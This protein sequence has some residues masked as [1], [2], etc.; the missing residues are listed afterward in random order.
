MGILWMQNRLYRIYR[1]VS[2]RSGLHHSH[3]VHLCFSL[4]LSS[5]FPCCF[6]RFLFP[7]LSSMMADVPTRADT[8]SKLMIQLLLIS[9]LTSES[10]R[11]SLLSRIYRASLNNQPSW[12]YLFFFV[13]ECQR[14]VLL[15][16][17]MDVQYWWDLCRSVQMWRI[18]IRPVDSS[19]LFHVTGTQRIDEILSGLSDDCCRHQKE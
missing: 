18:G 14:V 7:S 6:R 4:Y 17:P 10:I 3:L 16:L 1:C 5:V 19:N 11:Q 2:A 12:V 8:V 13:S 9:H 15:S